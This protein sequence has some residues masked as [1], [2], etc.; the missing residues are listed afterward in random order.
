MEKSSL[1]VEWLQIHAMVHAWFSSLQ[2][3]TLSRGQPRI[4]P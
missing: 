4:E 2:A 3:V 1:G